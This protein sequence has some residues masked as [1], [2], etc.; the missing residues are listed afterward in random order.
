MKDNQPHKA[1]ILLITCLTT[2]AIYLEPTT[3]LKA[4]NFLHIFRRFISRRGKPIKIISDNGTTFQLITK[5][6]QSINLTATIEWKFIPQFSPWQGGVYERFNS[7]IKA[8]FRRTIGSITLDFKEL[9]TFTTEVEA[10]INTRPLTY[11]STEP[12]SLTPLRPIDFLHPYVEISPSCET[13][14]FNECEL[15]A[16][17]LQEIWKKS[18]DCLNAFWKRWNKEYL[19]MLRER[20]GWSHKGPRLQSI[21]QPKVGDVVLL[22]ENFRPRNLWP[23]G[24]IV[25]VQNV[26]G[27]VRIAKVQLPNRK[28]YSRPINRL[29]LHENSTLTTDNKEIDNHQ[30]PAP[31]P[32]IL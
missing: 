14:D 32:Q 13:P 1:R 9:F 17:N 15:P 26:N 12:D 7:I 2:R 5:L 28:I 24:K 23:L 3:S 22:E 11:V 25:E 16:K 4:E 19:L 21:E 29:H 6:F 30:T 8:S 20:S 27:L 10:S 18:I 31:E